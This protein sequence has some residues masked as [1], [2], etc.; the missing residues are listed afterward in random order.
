MRSC[1]VFNHAVSHCGKH[2]EFCFRRLPCF[3]FAALISSDLG[4]GGLFS[5]IF[6]FVQYV[7]LCQ[8]LF[9]LLSLRSSDWL[10]SFFHIFVEYSRFL[11]LL[12]L[13]AIR[14]VLWSASFL[15]LILRVPFSSTIMLVVSHSID[16]VVTMLTLVNRPYWV[17]ILGWGC[18]FLWFSIAFFPLLYSVWLPVLFLIFSLALKSSPTITS[19]SFNFCLI[20]ISSL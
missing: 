7:P 20:C 6:V 15:A 16:S 8:L 11:G 19:F 4:M 12:T 9:L 14:M 13:I 10:F 18:Y 3:F 2:L 1:F 17:L 5:L